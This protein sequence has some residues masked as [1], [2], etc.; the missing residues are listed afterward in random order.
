MLVAHWANEAG[1]GVAV[2]R[3]PFGT[4]ALASGSDLILGPDA[5]PP[6]Y[7]RAVVRNMR[8]LVQELAGAGLTVGG[9]LAKVH[10]IDL[11]FVPVAELP[12]H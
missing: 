2:T 12:D 8:E 1:E 4:K 9:S 7:I 6:F 10:H 11:E 3:E 5:A